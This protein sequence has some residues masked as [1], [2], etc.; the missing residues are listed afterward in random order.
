[1]AQSFKRIKWISNIIIKWN[2]AERHN[3]TDQK[4]VKYYLDRYIKVF[5]AKSAIIKL[6][7]TIQLKPL[8]LMKNSISR[9]FRELK[10]RRMHQHKT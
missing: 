5:S 10:Y 2:T 8:S 4:T 6:L 3:Y 7:A 1:M 9:R